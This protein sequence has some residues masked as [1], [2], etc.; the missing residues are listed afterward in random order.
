MVMAYL[1]A[2]PGSSTGALFHSHDILAHPVAFRNSWRPS[3]LLM[4][5]FGVELRERQCTVHHPKFAPSHAGTQ[6]A[7]P[8]LSRFALKTEVYQQHTFGGHDT[9]DV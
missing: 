3:W 6:I 4:H 7:G 9:R 2:G 5:H 1:Y 8:I